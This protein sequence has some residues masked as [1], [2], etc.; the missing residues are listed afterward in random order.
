[1]KLK[2]I[3]ASILTA[4][5]IGGLVFTFSLDRTLE[6]EEKPK[7][8]EPNTFWWEKRAN[9]EGEFDQSKY[10][11]AIEKVNELKRNKKGNRGPLDN[12]WLQ[13]GP[14]NIGGRVNVINVSPTG[15]TIYAGSANGGVFRTLDAGATWSPIFDNYAFMSIGAIELDPSE[16]STIY[17]GTGDRNFGGGSYSGNGLY[18]STDYGN[19]WSNIGLASAGIL[20]D[21]KVNPTDAQNIVVG[22]LGDGFNKTL[23]RGI[24]ITTD[25]G[26]N[27]I[28]TLFV[29]DSSGVRDLIRD[30][31]NPD[32]LYCATAN[33]MNTFGNGTADGPDAKIFK[34]IDAGL[35]WTELTVGLPSS[36]Q[37]R[38]GITLSESNP[39]VLYA[40]YVGLDYNVLD[41]YKS[42]DAGAT[43]TALD[44]NN[45]NSGLDQNALGG[46]GWY[47]GTIYVSPYDENTIIIPGVEMWIS[48]DAGTNWTRNVPEWWTYEVHAD[49]HDVHFV[50]ANTLIIATDG[51]LYKT[52]DLGATWTDIENLPITQF[53][54][55]TAQGPSVGLYGGGAQDNGTMHGNAGTT[56][57]NRDFGG[58]GFR[59]EFSTDGSLNVY[60]TQRGG[61]HVDEFGFVE[62]LI[63]QP[64]ENLPWFTQYQLGEE[65]QDMMVGSDR[66]LYFNWVP[67]IF[68]PTAVTGNL[69]QNGQG[70]SG[71][72]SYRYISAIDRKKADELKALIGTS[73]G[74]V[75]DTRTDPDFGTA[76]TQNIKGNLPDFFVTSVNHSLTDSLTYFVSMNGYYPTVTTP[77]VFKTTDGGNTWNSISGDLPLIGINHL[78]VAEKENDQVIFAATDAGVFLTQNGGTNWEL[79]GTNL[80]SIEIVEVDIDYA[81]QKLIA[82][83]YGR[84]MWSYD[85]SFLNLSEN[86]LAVDEISISQENVY[87]NPTR[88]MLTITGK[89]IGEFSVY[90][91]SGDLVFTDNKKSTSHTINTDEFAKGTYVIRFGN[92]SQKFIKQ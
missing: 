19:T 60:E 42:I 62:T 30:K 87:P 78:L 91:L 50:D 63:F 88:D 49:K 13:E 80:P 29:S 10:I 70:I 79:I 24:F 7:S 23:D 32:I 76:T 69:T 17:L 89:F 5:F 43:W 82:G 34:S 45:V 72:E 21:V 61:I 25:G 31:S 37:S 26:A 84:S 55:V 9:I 73:D 15:D 46:F 66:L 11:S 33:R 90:S 86:I 48:T 59:A 83:T 2:L 58:D 18:K 22:A 4:F 57:W 51:G 56:D 12:Q 68:E 92:S 40:E 67:S 75:W 44:V 41:V 1:M 52:T 35:T 39:N 74:L 85:I 6:N 36:T 3:F 8:L 77:Y 65:M 16:D 20:T 38:I 47:F 81:N 14:Y 53:Y 64:N 71:A 28:N 27:W 54:D